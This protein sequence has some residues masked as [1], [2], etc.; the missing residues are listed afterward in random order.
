MDKHTTKNPSWWND[1][2]TGAWDRSKEAMKR[3]WEQTKNDVSKH[4]GKELKQNVA[5]TVKQAA[6]AEAIPPNGM[7]NAKGR[8]DFSSVE[9]AYRYGVGLSA[10]YAN[11]KD[12]NPD[13][14]SKVAGEWSTLSDPTPWS[15]AKGYVRR[16]FE[17]SRKS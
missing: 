6:G 3:D 5:D 16:G 10:Q 7:P 1:N 12:W 2:H 14:E 15:D 11:Q 17:K 9:P 13:F 4:S 8:G